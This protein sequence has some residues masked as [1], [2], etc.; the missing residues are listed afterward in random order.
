MDYARMAPSRLYGQMARRGLRGELCSFF[1]AWTGEF[2]PG[3]E[4][5]FGAAIEDGF[6]VPSVPAS[7]GSGL[8]LAMHRGRF[9]YTHVRQ[10]D[11]WQ[12]DE[13]AL[14]HAQLARDLFG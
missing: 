11:A 14:F 3:L 6:G 5:F 13:I 12:A 1:F 7:P 9:G 10:R 2:C 8:V 4:R